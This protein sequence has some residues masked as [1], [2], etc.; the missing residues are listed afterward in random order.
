MPR[1]AT[2]LSHRAAGLLTPPKHR[3][4]VCNPARQV[5]TAGADDDLGGVSG[6]GFP[7]PVHAPVR[8]RV[9][10]VASNQN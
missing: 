8:T 10:A 6:I 4:P 7:L 1:L 5:F 3:N 9:S 2:K